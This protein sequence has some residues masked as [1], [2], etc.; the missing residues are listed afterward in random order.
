[1][2][3]A[4]VSPPP[5]GHIY[6]RGDYAAATLRLIANARGRGVTWVDVADVVGG[7]HGS[8]SGVL[9][10]LH[11]EGRIVRLTERR[12][13]CKVYMLRG[14]AGLLPVD[15]PPVSKARITTCPHCG[16]DL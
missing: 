15:P 2:S 6:K 7:H 8:A 3:I 16:G 11:K 5:G 4:S 14:Y 9:S 12:G 10:K 1:M 13:R